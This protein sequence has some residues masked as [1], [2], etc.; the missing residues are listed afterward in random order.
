MRDLLFLAHRVPFPPDRG[1]KI[2]S[3]HILRHLR[4]DWR[5]HLCTF[6]ESEAD[7][8]PPA[9][10]TDLLAGCH[11]IRR[12]K[13][14]PVAALQALATG[15]PVSLTA[16]AHP[17]MTKAVRTVRRQGVAAAYIFSG[18]MAQYAGEEPTIMDMVD[19]DSAKFAALAERA[20]G[21][22]RIMLAREARLLG[23][24]ER[25]VAAGMAATLFV[26]EAEAALFRAGGGEGRIVAVENGID[27][28]VHDP[29]LVTPVAEA[30]PLIV[31]TGQMDYQPNIDA[32]THF[33]KAI[34]PLVRQAHAA[35]R[36]AIVGRAPTPAVRRLAGE[37]VIVTGEVPDTRIWL[38]AA[39]VCVAPLMLAR[40]IQNKVLE[41]MAMARPIVA[42]R[43]AAEGIDHGG[44]I[45]VADGDRDFA[46]K[47]IA[48]LSG[49]AANP[50]A[51]AQ[52]L[53]RYDWNARLAPLDQLLKDIV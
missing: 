29:A 11:I 43:A 38:A 7:L 52:V 10:F 20:A 40:G 2:R 32:V 26:S 53:D 22:K 16:F 31:F 19:V 4:R 50:A 51:R 35:V 33:A 37:A 24:F 18:Q 48:A 14:T 25:R 9:A 49:P 5:V 12:S 44:T 13:S 8:D 28:A 3:Y 15:A 21:L 36:F 46:D 30:G 6:G 47:V 17:A 23:G 45:A 27:A 39:A 41:A 34:L 42:S 1:D